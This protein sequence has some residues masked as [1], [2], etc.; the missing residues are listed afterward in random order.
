[1]F[2]LTATHADPDAGRALEALDHA[3]R[4][5]PFCRRCGAPMLP[6]ARGSALRLECATLQEAR[7]LLRR[8]FAD[9]TRRVVV[10]DAA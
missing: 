10:D 2:P 1:V 4:S 3:E 9:H 5:T 6:V 7:P 8:L